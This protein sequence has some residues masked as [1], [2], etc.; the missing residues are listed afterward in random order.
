MNFEGWMHEVDELCLGEYLMSIHDLPDM[1]FYD[2][3]ECGQTPEEFMAETI[4]D[5]AA[6]AHLVLS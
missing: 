4:P 6:L 3:Y 2:A 1:E 5:L